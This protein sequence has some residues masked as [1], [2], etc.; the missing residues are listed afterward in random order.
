VDCG[1][2]GWKTSEDFKEVVVDRSVTRILV[3]LNI[4]GSGMTGH[5]INV[6]DMDPV[7]TANKIRQYPGL[8]V[9]IKNAHFGPPGWESVRRALEAGRLSKTPVILDNHIQTRT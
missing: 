9:G 2:A 4:V 3:F 8:I 6:E 7:A 1:G 5:E